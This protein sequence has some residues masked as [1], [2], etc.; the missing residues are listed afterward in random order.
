MGE[1]KGALTVHASGGASHRKTGSA[2][3]LATA[4]Q[5]Q[6]HWNW[7]RKTLFIRNALWF[8]APQL[9][10]LLRNPGLSLSTSTALCSLEG[11]V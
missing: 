5:C 1:R 11:S 3:G 2:Q 4:A 6:T 10:A 9:A 7:G 8:S